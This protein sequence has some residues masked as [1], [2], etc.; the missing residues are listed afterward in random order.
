MFKGLVD[1]YKKTYR[2]YGHDEQKMFISVHSHGY[3]AETYK[4]AFET[5]YPSIEQAMNVI[6]KER[7]WSKYTK[8]TYE[9]TNSM[10]GALYVGDSEYVAKKIIHLKQILG[11]DRFALHVPVGHLD[12][13]KVMKSIEL[14]G[15][16]VKP[17][18]D[19][20]LSKN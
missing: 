10:E 7:G 1:L 17:L 20:E 5:Y 11:I 15:T 6:G 2:E 4:E 8:Q 9:H 13:D 3:V 12:H 16:K 18:V 19:Q 14:F